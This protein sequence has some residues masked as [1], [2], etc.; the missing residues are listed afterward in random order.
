VLLR[1]IVWKSSSQKPTQVPHHT[2]QASFIYDNVGGRCGVKSTTMMWDPFFR[3]IFS[4]FG[5]SN[6]AKNR[7]GWSAESKKISRNFNWL[8][9]LNILS[10]FWRFLADF[11]A[12]FWT[13]GTGLSGQRPEG[14][15]AKPLWGGCTPGPLVTL[16]PTLSDFQ[17][18]RQI[19][20][21]RFSSGDPNNRIFGYLG[22]PNNRTTE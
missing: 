9:W 2:L 5:Q 22:D 14:A 19:Q 17:I 8:I 16:C 7:G 12:D 10:E 20:F 13:V 3:L 6:T 21:L 1:V 11:S 18:Y 4:L 15:I